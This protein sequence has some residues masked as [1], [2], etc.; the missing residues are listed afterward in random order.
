M[1]ILNFNI[2]NFI[3]IFIFSLLKFNTCQSNLQLFLLNYNIKYNNNNLFLLFINTYF[4]NFLENYRYT[5]L[6]NS[7]LYF[8][9]NIEKTLNDKLL[10]YSRIFNVQNQYYILNNNNN[11]LLLKNKISNKCIFNNSIV[12]SYTDNFYKTNIISSLSPRMQASALR[13]KYKILF[14]N[15][16]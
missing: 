12:T 8:T 9:D 13:Y 16:L 5:K 15:Y 1:H 4:N 6:N 7:H 2:F 14:S 3:L 10:T 11:N